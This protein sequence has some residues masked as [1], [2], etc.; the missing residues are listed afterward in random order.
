[1]MLFGCIFRCLDPVLTVAAGLSFRSPFV[2]PF[3]KREEADKAKKK[4]AVQNSD[5]LT[6]LKAYRGWL[7]AAERHTERTYCF[8][9][10]LSA[11]TLR[12]I[13]QMKVQFL[14][15][16]IEI[17]FLDPSKLPAGGRGGKGGGGRGRGGGRGGRLSLQGE[18]AMFGGEW[19]NTNSAH[20]SLAK[21]V[22][23]AGLYPNVVQVQREEPRRKPKREDD[24]PARAPRAPKLLSREGSEV[25]VHPMSVNFSSV[26]F[27]SPMLLYF[28][29]V[30]TTKV[31]VRDATMITPYPL[32]LF[33]G[34]LEVKHEEKLIVVDDWLS[35]VSMGKVAVLISG[36]SS[37]QSKHACS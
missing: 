27:E 22:L 30:K 12:M 1:M 34:E 37:R 23:C 17:G 21:A 31:Y 13:R 8:G 20:M 29:K 3:E 7:A 26:A 2:A 25:F 16:L 33:G 4:F 36:A 32:L 35:F 24:R 19:Y 6:L 18:R 9:N 11:N 5:H 28:E 15:L 10:F 14:E